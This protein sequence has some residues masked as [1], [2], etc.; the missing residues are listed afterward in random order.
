MRRLWQEDMAL[1]LVDF[2]SLA[3]M[4]CMNCAIYVRYTQVQ[5]LQAHD[6]AKSRWPHVLWAHVDAQGLHL[7]NVRG[8]LDN[9]DA[10]SQK[11]AR[12]R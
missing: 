3:E 11:L 2:G 7:R 5:P 1:N 10:A 9:S 6:I 4:F 12:F 8:V